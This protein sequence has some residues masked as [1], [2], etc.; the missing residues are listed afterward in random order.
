[1]RLGLLSF[2]SP[3]FLINLG[4]CVLNFMPSLSFLDALFF[5]YLRIFSER[6]LFK[7]RTDLFR[8]AAPEADADLFSLIR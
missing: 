4:W 7:S 2:L 3:N 1:M 8:P 6:F 5:V